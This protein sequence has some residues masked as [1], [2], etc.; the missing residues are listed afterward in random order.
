MSDL[1][2]TLPDQL[3]DEL[4]DRVAARLAAQQR[5]PEPWLDVDG[6]ARHLGY[7]DNLTRGRRR[8]YDLANAASSNNFPVHRDGRRLL[9]K[10][11]ELDAWIAAQSTTST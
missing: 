8:I 4:A 3:I 2:L 5:Q 10:A 9:F 6:A 1:M 7:S 11:S